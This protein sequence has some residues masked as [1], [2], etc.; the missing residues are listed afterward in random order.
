MDILWGDIPILWAF[1][2]LLLNTISITLSSLKFE[3]EWSYSVK[4]INSPFQ[5]HKDI[6]G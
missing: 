1:R 2:I 4:W 5:N 3:E 6:Y